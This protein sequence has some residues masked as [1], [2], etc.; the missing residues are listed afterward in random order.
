LELA[1]LITAAQRDVDHC[2][3]LRLWGA[4]VFRPG[5]VVY[6]VKSITAKGDTLRVELFL[7]LDNS[8]DVVEV[9]S[10]EGGRIKD[11]S[12]KISRAAAVRWNGGLCKRPPGSMDPALHLGD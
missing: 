1:E 11:G 7:A 2:S 5:D 6:S 4:N 3:V 9:D 8:T 10:P 12:L